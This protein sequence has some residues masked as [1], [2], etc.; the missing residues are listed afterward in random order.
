[1]IIALLI[2]VVFAGQG[3][4]TT[5]VGAASRDGIDIGTAV[6]P[7]WFAER[8][9]TD[10]VGSQFNVLEPENAMKFEPIH[11]RPNTD[12]N[13]YDFSAADEIVSF[14]EQHHQKVRGHCLVWYRQVPRWL[15]GGSFTPGQ[16]ADILHKHMQ[17]V[18]G[19]Y[20][21]KVFAWDVVNEAIN[22]D[23]S[24]RPSV[25]YDH[26]GF[27]FAGQGTAYIE[28]AFRWAHEADPHAKLFYNDYSDELPNPKAN[29]IYAMLKDFKARHVPVDG[30][31][32]QCHLW[33]GF[34]SPANLQAFSANLKRFAD[35]G[36]VIHITELDLPLHSSS[37]EAFQQEALLYHD[38]V[39]VAKSVPAVKMIQTW[40]FTDKHSWISNPALG[41]GWGLPWDADYNKK[42]AWGAMMEA[43][44]GK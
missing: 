38:V 13:P 3:G 4:P 33:Q 9:Y 44:R 42:P 18:M 35:L 22:D 10:I 11:P 21:G 43:L 16:M 5:L 26:P 8:P 30:V 20:E 27:G 6:D 14:A 29:A 1:M 34:N 28:Q 7:R 40:G 19:R 12:P 25:W 2:G 17:T 31:G 37:A 23:G 36:L 15:T 24:M 32:F 39:Q 41:T